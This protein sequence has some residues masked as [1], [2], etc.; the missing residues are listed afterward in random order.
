MQEPVTFAFSLRSPYAWLAARIVLPRV[1]PD[2]ALRWTPLY[3]LPSFRNFGDL[4]PTKVRYIIE[5]LRRLAKTYDLTLG[6]PP[7]AEP[8]WS[9]PHTAFVQAERAGAGPAFARALMDARWSRGEDV[10]S[11]PTLRRAAEQVGLDPDPVLAAAADPRERAALVERIQRGYDER[12]IF[13][14]PMFV[15][16]D[17]A[18]FWGHD[19]MAWALEHGFVRAVDAA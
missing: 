19:R 5:D 18:R 17:G 8:D 15:L 3:P 1:H 13:G 12:G 14:V 9:V 11:E 2:V 10:A 7:A 6:R 16:P 4:L